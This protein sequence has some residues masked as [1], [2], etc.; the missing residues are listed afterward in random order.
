[1]GWPSD[2]NAW[3]VEVPTTGT[4]V[5]RAG[6]G[7]CQLRD[8]SAR[9]RGGQGNGQTHRTRRTAGFSDS[10]YCLP[11]VSKSIWRL[12]LTAL[13]QLNST[14]LRHGLYKARANSPDSVVQ[15]DLTVDQVRPGR[16]VGV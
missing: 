5:G 16:R 3:L 6:E 1:M 9:R 2:L 10:L 14:E 7:F 13:R 8:D 15:V 12:F 11:P 4:K